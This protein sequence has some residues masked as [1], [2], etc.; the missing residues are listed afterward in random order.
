MNK[1]LRLS[2]IALLAVFCNA[3]AFAEVYKTLTF[4][5]DNQANNQISAYTEAWTA[6]IGTDSWTIKNFNNNKWSSWTYI[7]AGRKNNASVASI[8]TDFA[9]D[10]PVNYVAMTIDKVTASKINSIKLNVSNDKAG[11]DVVETVTAGTIAQGELKLEVTTPKANCYYQIVI[12][13]ASGTANGLIQ[14]SKVVYD[15]TVSGPVKQEAD[16]KFSEENITIKQGD[17]F[18]APTFT[19]ATTAAVTFASDN[20]AVATVDATGTISLAGGIGT[21]VITATSVANE[22]YKAGTATCTI[23]VAKPMTIAEAQAA[24]TETA[25]HVEGTVVAT[26]AR[27]CLIGDETGYIYYYANGSH[28]YVVGDKLEVLGAVS[29][30]NGFNQFTNTAIIT[31]VGTETVTHPTAQSMTGADVTAW[32]AAPEIKYVTITGALN[33]SGNYYNVT[34]DDTEIVGSIVSPDE[35]LKAQLTTGNSYAITGYAIYVSGNKTKYMNILP[36]SVADPT[37]INGITTDAANENAP[38]YNLAGQRVNKTAKGIL[39]QNGK[40]FVNK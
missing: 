22:E 30:Y 26:C 9:I 36:I 2:L 20:E 40:K 37:G 8:N 15:A 23:T 10:M 16:L 34:I 4:P 32:A 38:I 33:I 7:R 11:T 28:E 27:G 17:A 14:I 19:K 18:T 5:D 3:G 24:A 6:K 12:D 1:I 31:K 21:A 39:I 35:A 29:A 25:C 13:C